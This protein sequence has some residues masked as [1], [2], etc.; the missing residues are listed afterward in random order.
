MTLAYLDTSSGIAGDMTLAALIDAGADVDYIRHQVASL[1]LADVEL[2]FSETQRHCFRALR[3]DVLHPPEHAHR[4]LSDIQQLISGSQLTA[5]ESSLALRLFERLGQAEARVH[6]TTL[7]EVHFH[8]VGAIDSIVD[9]VGVAVAIC[10]LNIQRIIASPTPTGSGT[11][12]IAHG[13]VTVPAPAT[14]ELLKG[15]PV[16]E[17]RIQCE[18]TTPTGAAILA[19]LADGFGPLPS[20]EIQSVGYGAGHKELPEQANVLRVILGNPL[21]ATGQ[22]N[23]RDEVVVL[24]TNIDDASGEKLGYAIEKLW[25]S[26]PL[27]VYTAPISMKKNRPGVLLSVICRPSQQ[28]ALESLMLEVTGSLGIRAS[29]LAR[30]IL[31]RKIIDVDTE[32]GTARVKVSWAQDADGQSQVRIAPEFED[33]RQL[34]ETHHQSL[35]QV[36][37]LVQAAASK[38]AERLS[39]PAELVPNTLS[40]RQI[41]P[42]TRTW[43][44]Y[45]SPTPVP[46]QDHD[47]AHDHDH[48]HDHHDHHHH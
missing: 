31:P 48:H 47:H 11:I 12:T 26:E 30:R 38:V 21:D 22:M 24:E 3:L 40:R 36:F 4:H 9:I 28:E 34:A 8:E 14:A 1:G 35:D 39:P 13:P 16:R 45:E 17:S 18:L 44:Q 15:I 43:P 42:D 2:R 29:R 25:S 19:T 33:C 7:E 46:S 23:Q 37:R 10:N 5:R 41:S 6:G 20:M 27:D 32:L